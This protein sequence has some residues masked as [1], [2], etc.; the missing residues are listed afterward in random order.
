LARDA[1]LVPL[2]EGTAVA[3]LVLNVL[4]PG[5][6]TLVTGRTGKG[7]AQLTLFLLGVPLCLVLIG[8]PMVVGSWIWA[9]A[10]SINTVDQAHRA[11]ETRQLRP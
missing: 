10:T 8:L 3:G 1:A 7:L 2:S 11:A 9:L 4:F 5:V 6:G